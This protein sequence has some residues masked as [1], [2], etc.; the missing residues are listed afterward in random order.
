MTSVHFGWID[1]PDHPTDAGHGPG[2]S[3]GQPTANADKTAPAGDDCGESRYPAELGEF[4]AD[5]SVSPCA[6]E[7]VSRMPPARNSACHTERDKRRNR[8]PSVQ[9]PSSEHADL[10]RRLPGGCRWPANCSDAPPSCDDMATERQLPAIISSCRHHFRFRGIRP[11]LRL[12]EVQ[13]PRKMT[14]R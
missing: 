14:S 7:G 5:L 6:L 9:Q 13:R 2:S 11:H 12:H 8:V 3:H 4:A 1:F 10:Q